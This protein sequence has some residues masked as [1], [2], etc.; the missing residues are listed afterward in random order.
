MDRLLKDAMKTRMTQP[1]NCPDA[2]QLAAWADGTIFGAAAEGLESHLADCERCQAVLAAFVAT[3]PVPTLVAV[4]P[5]EA[6]TPIEQAPEVRTAPRAARMP[7]VWWGAAAA[8]LLLWLAWPKPA[9]VIPPAESIARSET[10]APAAGAVATPQGSPALTPLVT[11]VIGPA[12]RQTAEAAK[13]SQKTANQT[14]AKANPAARVAEPSP[15]PVTAG[16]ATAAA[17]P[18]PAPPPATVPPDMIQTRQ[19]PVTD[20]AMMQTASR[21]ESTTMSFLVR[22]PDGGVEFGPTDAVASVTL[23]PTR[24][25]VGGG[26]GR[27]NPLKAIR[28]RVLL[29]G[30]VE[31]TI[32]GG[33]NWKRIVLDPAISITTGAS[34]SEVVC[35]LVGKSGAVLKSTDGGATF[36]QV[37][38]PISA[39]LVSID[40][41]DALVATVATGDGRRLTTTNGGQT[42]QRE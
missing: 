30:L 35:W 27:G 33:T 20:V 42:W 31:K 15:K 29:S 3:E 11:P 16:A 12:P 22:L 26:G 39:D 21:S 9:Q 6:P 23:T 8:S 4:P 32:D 5:T 10:S 38:K 36:V 37:T 18:P 24:Q 7:Y 28:W 41:A 13:S 2:E 19:K 40:A 25:G 1:G 17:P 14:L 34:P